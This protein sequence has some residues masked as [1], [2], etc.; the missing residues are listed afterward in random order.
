M[1]KIAVLS[2]LYCSLSLSHTNC[3][4]LIFQ[5]C[6]QLTIACAESRNPCFHL[7][8]LKK[9]ACLLTRR[10]QS[11]QLVRTHFLYIYS[12]QR[13]HDTY[14]CNHTG[15]VACMNRIVN[16]NKIRTHTHTHERLDG[17]TTG[18]AME[19]FVQTTM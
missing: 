15:Q 14:T 2:I 6:T 13:S 5:Y 4:S 16:K 7:S 9:S 18:V 11:G 12:N 8:A 19:L 3:Y 17:L 10:K 1:W